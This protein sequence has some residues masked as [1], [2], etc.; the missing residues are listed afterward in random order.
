MR[1]D[2]RRATGFARAAAV[3]VA[4]VA[5]V[6]VEGGPHARAQAFQAVRSALGLVLYVAARRVDRFDSVLGTEG[7]PGSAAVLVVPAALAPRGRAS[8]SVAG[9]VGVPVRLGRR[10]PAK[11]AA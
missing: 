7:W 6:L 11:E 9:C 10:Q 5:L 4:G 2:G 8:F 3:A 1:A